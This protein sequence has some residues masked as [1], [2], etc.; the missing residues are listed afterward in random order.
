MPLIFPQAC[1]T[2]FVTAVKNKYKYILLENDTL[3]IVTYEYISNN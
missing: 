2:C 1:A 3:Y